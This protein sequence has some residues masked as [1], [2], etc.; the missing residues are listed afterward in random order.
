MMKCIFSSPWNHSQRLTWRARSLLQKISTPYAILD[1]HFSKFAPNIFAVATSIGTV[2]FYSCDVEAGSE[3][4]LKQISIIKVADPAV[5]ILSLAW[6][7]CSAWPSTV[8][9]S[10][11]TGQIGILNYGIQDAAVR[12][13][14]AHSLEAWTIAWSTIN[15]L[16]DSPYLYSGGDDS[17]LSVHTIHDILHIETPDT[18]QSAHMEY[19]SRSR[20]IKTHGA[21]VTA[22][23]PLMTGSKIDRE[24][25]L[26]GSYDE[27]LRV[28]A[29]QLPGR[30]TKILVEKRLGGGV[31]R[32]KQLGS[33]QA[34]P[35]DG[36]RFIILAS[37]MHAGVKV[38]E[39]N[40]SAEEKWSIRILG[41]FVE[42]L[43]MNYA[44]DAR[45]ENHDG[46]S[47][48]RMYI[49]SSFYD[50]RLCVWEMKDD[51]EDSQVET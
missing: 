16:D 5:L 19:E 27:F 8:A 9:V 21:G 46:A 48:S 31:W 28:L 17:V 39:V 13:V 37:C 22:I 35:T 10:L 34:T 44:S 6:S 47:K 30:R 18:E 14:P 24:T 33:S 1:L 3:D 45:E 41:C 2:C 32:L 43:S 12:L 4:S 49:S 26:T 11:S 51:P 36:K 23:L 42:H 15:A 25:L 38:V 7:V 40:R 50:K 29:P 20:D